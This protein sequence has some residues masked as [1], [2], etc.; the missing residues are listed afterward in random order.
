MIKFKLIVLVILVL[1]L[2]VITLR[3]RQAPSETYVNSHQ[4]EAYI[5]HIATNALTPEYPEEAVRSGL[6]GLVDVGVRF[7]EN[8]NF[9]RLKILQSPDRL[10]SEAVDS[11][12]KHW[13]VGRHLVVGGSDGSGVP[14][15]YFGELRFLFVITNGVGHVEIPSLDDQKVMSPAFRKITEGGKRSLSTSKS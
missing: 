15:R 14:V 10:L 12:V 4:T 6:S 3:G 1:S 11:A 13:T 2:G 8:G 7:D 5:R 9:N